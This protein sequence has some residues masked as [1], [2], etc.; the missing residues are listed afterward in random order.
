MR[1]LASLCR[2]RAF[3]SKVG[4]LAH[5][6]V[7]AVKALLAVAQYGEVA[8]HAFSDTHPHVRERAV[9]SRA[10][11]CIR[12]VYA[13]RRALWGGVMAAGWPSFRRKINK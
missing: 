3:L 6:L 5:V 9:G 12:E 7:C 10:S 8:A 4:A 2:A 13:Q 1:E 11:A